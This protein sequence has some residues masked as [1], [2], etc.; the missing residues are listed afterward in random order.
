VTA[1]KIVM[2]ATNYRAL[3]DLIDRL[4]AAALAPERWPDFL[5]AAAAMFDA[6]NAFVCQ[7]RHRREF[8][9][10]IGLS[11]RKRDMMPVR[12]YATLIDEDPRARRFSASAGRPVHCG[13]GVAR[14]TV[15]ASR[16]YR[17]YLKPLGIEY[18]MVVGFPAGD[19][20]THDLGLLRGP[21]GKAFDAADCDLLSEITPHIE[22]AFAIRR[23]LDARPAPCA[24]PPP[25]RKAVPVESV[26]QQRLGLSP[27]QARVT[28]MLSAGRSVKEIAKTL[29][30]A[31]DSVRQYLKRIYQRTGTQR[32]TDLVR[33]A[34]CAG[35][36]AD[37]A[38]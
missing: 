26:L 4:Y 14:A 20:I 21:S 37:P 5:S 11:T 29:G 19:G 13:I 6:R 22:R 36:A 25:A 33:V 18:T 24:L 10:Y 17:E 32:Q 15:R 30:I 34:L 3:I 31:D 16:A 27:T 8:V 1:E 23:A 28:A 35:D 7:L 2:P 12:R 9:E 38:T